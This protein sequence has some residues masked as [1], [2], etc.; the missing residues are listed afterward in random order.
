[1]EERDKWIEALGRV[2]YGPV[3][4]GMFGT[5]LC[6]QVQR[7]VHRV[8]TDLFVDTSRYSFLLLHHIVLVIR[9]GLDVERS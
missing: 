9:H 5:D 7:E 3:G 8:E 4:G 1:M 6:D 2:V